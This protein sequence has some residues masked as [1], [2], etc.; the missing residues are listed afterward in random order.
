MQQQITALQQQLSIQEN[1]NTN[2][3]K[4]HNQPTA[5]VQC[6]TDENELP[7]EVEWITASSRKNKKIKINPSPDSSPDRRMNSKTPQQIKENERKEPKP[8]PI[9][10]SNITDYDTLYT[11]LKKNS[12][13]FKVTTRNNDQVKI[14]TEDRQAFKCTIT[15]LKELS[16]QWH[17]YEDKETRDLK[18]MARGLLPTANCREIIDELQKKKL[19]CKDAVNIIKKIKIETDKGGNTVK[20]SLPLFMFTFKCKENMKAVFG[21]NNPG[22]NSQNSIFKRTESNSTM[23][24]VSATWTHAKILPKTAKIY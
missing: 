18:V 2:K 6:E 1:I 7:K 11:T 4:N 22:S 20:K 14:N 12:T 3:I 19:L 13:S 17:S 9:F 16:L 21:I 10:V 24:T 23:Q 15:C 8:P 5:S